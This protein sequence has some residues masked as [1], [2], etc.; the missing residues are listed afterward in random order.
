MDQG[1]TNE[2]LERRISEAIEP[3]LPEKG[4]LNISPC[5]AWLWVSG[6]VVPMPWLSDDGANCRLLDLMLDAGVHL[7]FIR[8]AAGGVCLWMNYAEHY[9]ESRRKIVALA[10]LA[11]AETPKGKAELEKRRN[12]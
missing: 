6:K 10:F 3:N 8:Q 2:E 12:L 5:A 11:W 1:M 9:I 4:W 7:T